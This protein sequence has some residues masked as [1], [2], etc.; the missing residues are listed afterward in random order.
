MK[1]FKLLA[2]V[3]FT[4]SIIGLSSCVTRRTVKDG[5]GNTIYKETLI[6]RPFQSDKK[7]EQ[8]VF[9]KEVELGVY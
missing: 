4:F 3:L 1:L 2:L 5:G 8:Q 9:D 6:K 7:T